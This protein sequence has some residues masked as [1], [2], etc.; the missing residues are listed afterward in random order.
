MINT[1]DLTGM[2]S[3]L[4]SVKLLG[5]VRPDPSTFVEQTMPD[6]KGCGRSV[7]RMALKLDQLVEET[8]FEYINE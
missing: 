7:V 2:N 3:L 4:F 6:D 1:G 5:D 8:L